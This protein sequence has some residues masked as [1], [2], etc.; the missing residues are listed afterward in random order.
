MDFPELELADAL[1]MIV[2]IQKEHLMTFL[3][4][5][6]TVMMNKQTWLFPID[7]HLCIVCDTQALCQLHV[8][9]FF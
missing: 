8:L 7:I 5:M 3:H 4:Q 1:K 6:M 9:T 2:R